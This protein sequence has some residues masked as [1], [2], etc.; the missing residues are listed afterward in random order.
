[1]S[2]PIYDQLTRERYHDAS[3]HVPIQPAED[4]VNLATIEQDARERVEDVVAKGREVLDEV[5]PKLA[6]AAADAEADPLVQAI[7]ATVL[8][9]AD[10][11]FIAS[12]VTRLGQA[13]AA[14]EGDATVLDD[15]GPP[16]APEDVPA[17][18]SGAPVV[19]GT[20]G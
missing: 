5:L 18:A 4:P 9:P 11:E 3:C 13:A 20:A 2:A 15:Q 12:L 14:A 7:E 17:A 8:S 6:K 1:M 10:R 19:A 16:D